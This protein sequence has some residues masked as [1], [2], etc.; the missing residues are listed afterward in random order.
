M[1]ILSA[2][3]DCLQN[4]LTEKCGS[5]SSCFKL[6]FKINTIVDN[7]VKSITV[8]CDVIGVTHDFNL[9]FI[10]W[11]EDSVSLNDFPDALFLFGESRVLSWNLGLILDLKLLGNIFK[12]IDI[13]IV[14]YFLVSLNIWSS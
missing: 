10:I 3:I 11:L 5:F 6:D 8:L 9:T 12:N 13:S 2:K 1:S 14:K 7:D 4:L